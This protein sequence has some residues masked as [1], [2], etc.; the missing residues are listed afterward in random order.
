MDRTS[1]LKEI[2]R[3][4]VKEYLKPFDLDENVNSAAELKSIVESRPF[5]EF[6]QKLLRELLEVVQSRED[7]PKVDKET[8]TIHSQGS[9]LRVPEKI[10]FHQPLSEPESSFS[11]SLTQ[12][13]DYLC[14]NDKHLSELVHSL[15]P[16][17][18]DVQRRREALRQI[19]A[20]PSFETQVCDAWE[21]AP[22][23]P[24]AEKRLVDRPERNESRNSQE[25][26]LP[27]YGIRQ[28]LYDALVD[29]DTELN[30]FALK[31][32]AKAFSS[33]FGNVKECYALF[34]DY[35]E[36]KFTTDGSSIPTISGGLDISNSEIEKL[37]RC[38][39]LLLDFHKKLPNC[40]LRYSEKLMGV[41]MDRCL[42]L[43][44][45][46]CLPS[47][48]VHLS[49]PERRLTPLHIVS[50]L[51]PTAQWF[52]LW[53]RGAY[54]CRPML[55]RLTKNKQ[56]VSTWM[57]SCVC[58]F[59]RK[60][61]SSTQINRSNFYSCSH[62]EAAYF[63]HSLHA[64]TTL[65]C[66]RETHSKILPI[67]ISKEVIKQ[68]TDRDK[69]TLIKGKALPTRTF[70]KLFVEFILSLKH[71]ETTVDIG[72]K[73]LHQLVDKCFQRLALSPVATVFCFGL[74]VDDI[75]LSTAKRNKRFSGLSNLSKDSNQSVIDIVLFHIQVFVDNLLKMSGPSGETVNL[76]VCVLS[77]AVV[78]ICS[79]TQGRE[80]FTHPKAARQMQV[81]AK[82][83][84]KC[85][86]AI[87]NTNLE[88]A[89]RESGSVV[90]ILVKVVGHLCDALS[91]TFLITHSRQIRGHFEVPQKV[92]ELLK[93]LRSKH[94][95]TS[96]NTFL[97][98]GI[99]NVVELFEKSVETFL[100]ALLKT[101][102]GVQLVESFGLLSYC[103]QS[104]LSPFSLAQNYSYLEADLLVSQI[105]SCAEGFRSLEKTSFV[106]HRFLEVWK[107]L[108]GCET[109][110][111]ALAEGGD[112]DMEFSL[113][114]LLDDGGYRDHGALL[115]SDLPESEIQKPFNRLV[116]LFANF[117]AVFE[118][119]SRDSSR[120]VS[121][122]SFQT[123]P[124]F[125]LAFIDRAVMLDSATKLAKLC[126]PDETRVF[127]LRFLSAIVSSLDTFLLLESQFGI[128]S[129]LLNA[130]LQ[131]SLDQEAVVVDGRFLID[132]GLIERNR[133]LV[134]CSILGG[135]NE[136]YL[137]PRSLCEH[138]TDP[139]PYPIVTALNSDQLEKYTQKSKKFSNCPQC[140]DDLEPAPM[141][142]KRPTNATL[143][144][145]VI[146]SLIHPIN[147][148]CKT[149]NQIFFKF[150]RLRVKIR[151][152]TKFLPQMNKQIP[153][154]GSLFDACLR[155]MSSR[156][157]VTSSPSPPN[158]DSSLT[159]TW[160]ETAMGLV[161]DYGCRVH[162]LDTTV[163]PSSRKHD[164]ADLLAY[165]DGLRILSRVSQKDLQHPNNVDGNVEKHQMSGE[166]F[167]PF[168]WFVGLIF[169]LFNGSTSRAVDFLNRFQDTSLAHYLWAPSPVEMPSSHHYTI[170]HVFEV[171]FASELPQLYNTFQLS[172]Y[173]PSMV[174]RCWLRQYYLN[175]LDW[176]EIQDFFLL[177][178][179][180]GAEIIVFS[181]VTIMRHL[182]TR[183][184]T[185][186]QA[187]NHLL[188][189]LEEPI[190][191]FRFVDNLDFLE[192]L[193]DKYNEYVSAELASSPLD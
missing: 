181:A 85:L 16:R 168:D 127:G 10:R 119:L 48:E 142:L 50:L 27:V 102:R 188:M 115:P 96:N 84:S 191:G 11:S 65:L 192:L 14:L 66:F 156:K 170:C 141:N 37:L 81:I 82:I 94:K 101:P 15:D 178:L 21:A 72:G 139:Y 184:T 165:T 167:R 104:L 30:F 108:E 176:S 2:I 33:T 125:L 140:V 175:Y 87:A 80:Y 46:G 173:S 57:T 160:K 149:E 148:Q 129:M 1:I 112:E 49:S 99:L 147:G 90:E 128:R 79:T 31:F 41:L 118:S 144:S 172:G 113:D 97:H 70:I 124:K 110:G 24:T 131:N 62:L 126:R 132:E 6:R 47:L 154:I 177:C 63:L 59:L 43:L 42:S 153:E 171:V 54:G 152:L 120:I 146:S 78:N 77:Q 51:D 28:G 88:V 23:T 25:I 122:R 61:G 91:K 19:V 40:W 18:Y 45:I 52:S 95:E 3:A 4:R 92:L 159:P 74:S 190:E 67:T 123:I 26:A 75:P 157:Q 106:E 35:L 135:P 64:L 93:I 71:T 121:G 76:N 69:A 166:T 98:Y 105:T 114:D 13:I 107:L 22:E 109:E 162:V 73:T 182:S 44:L 187:Q 36:E 174:L 186:L 163:P 158:V 130:Q 161:I 12:G 136:R 180:Y 116:N 183:L 164:L 111:T 151:N 20:T 17:S 138:N 169:L 143:V 32:I 137:P 193:A 8:V 179:L 133:L 86:E 145:I 189:L 56:I 103:T 58:V 38:F 55:K 83:L 53:M 9:P 155:A 134:K 68:L 117:T 5:Y 89:C 39:C 185:A 150:P 34:V 7:I 100:L 29:E 60:P